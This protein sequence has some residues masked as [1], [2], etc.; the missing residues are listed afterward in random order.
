MSEADSPA[1]LL[2]KRK[3][4]DDATHL[5][6][7]CSDGQVTIGND[8]LHALCEKGNVLNGLIFGRQGGVG[9][10]HPPNLDIFCG[11]SQDLVNLLRACVK[12]QHPTDA[13]AKQLYQ[14]GDLRIFADT[15]G[16]FPVVDKVLESE[17][18]RIIEEERV[19]RRAAKSPE[20]DAANLFDWQVVAHEAL[21]SNLQA[22]FKRCQTRG[23]TYI[24]CQNVQCQY[25]MSPGF[26]F[27]RRER[28]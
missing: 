25:G 3:T 12:G 8:E 16:G 5:S 27:F 15:F 11:W 17:D 23:F 9:E 26:Y 2:G 6:F 19:S 10:L 13:R 22:E 18:R 28:R 24:S 21:P 7:K 4:R 20:E 14:S 1:T